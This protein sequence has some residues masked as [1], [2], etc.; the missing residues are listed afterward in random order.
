MVR[1]SLVAL[2]LLAAGSASA[3][4]RRAERLPDCER[5]ARGLDL[6]AGE[7]ELMCGAG[8]DDLPRLPEGR[9]TLP[10]EP[11]G[12]EERCQKFDD[13][14]QCLFRTRCERQ[15]ACLK[16]TVCDRFDDWGKCLS[17]AAKTT[18]R[19][20]GRRP[21]SASCESRCQRYDDRGEECLFKPVCEWDGECM[22][23]S[24]CQR[25]DDWGKCVAET[26][27]LSCPAFGRSGRPVSC[28]ES[29]QKFD[30]WDKCL[31]RTRC[32]KD[33]A[34]LRA[35]RCERFDDWGKCLSEATSVSCD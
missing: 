10:A 26:G 5:V 2:A 12:C 29:C 34:C 11:T 30:D 23:K 17:E 20:G 35:T 21:V 13:W 7:R 28:E 24:D 22:R 4:A 14:G 9:P 15:G 31:F 32:E 19:T 33:G 1:F 3:Q 6:P 8:G 16:E 25:F 18:C 27:T